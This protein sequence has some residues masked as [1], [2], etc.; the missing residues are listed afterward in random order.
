MIYSNFQEYLYF[1]S[2]KR[3]PIALNHRALYD[4]QSGTRLEGIETE[5]HAIGVVFTLF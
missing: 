2:S 1:C 4:L 5:R 3:R